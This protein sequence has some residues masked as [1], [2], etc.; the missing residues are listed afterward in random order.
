MS[1]K[2]FKDRKTLIS[3]GNTSITIQPYKL[4]DIPSLEYR[5]SVWDDIYHRYRPIALDYDKEE[6][7]LYLPSALKVN[8]LEKA[9]T[10]MNGSVVENVKSDPKTRAVFNMK[11]SPRDDIQIKALDFLLG[12]GQYVTNAYYPR[13]LLSLDTGG[14]KTFCALAAISYMKVR[15]AI[16][17]PDQALIDRWIDEIYKITDL[18]E[19]DIYI[20]KGLDSIKKIKKNI[21]DKKI[22][23]ISHRTLTSFGKHYGWTKVTKLFKI[24]KIG[25]KVFDEAHKEFRNISKIDLYTNTDKTIYLTATA[26]R[27]QLKENKI[28]QTVYS[29][30]PQLVIKNNSREENH[31]NT[32]ILQYNSNPSFNDRHKCKSIKGFSAIKFM[33][34]NMS[35]GKLAFLRA[36]EVFMNTVLSYEDGR[37]LIM[38]GLIDMIYMLEKHLKDQY[39]QYADEIGLYCSSVSKAEKENTIKNKRII[40]T[41]FKSLGTGVDIDNLKFICMSEPYSSSV[42]AKQGSGRLRQEGWY[43]ETVDIGFPDCQRQFESRKKTLIRKSKKFKIIKM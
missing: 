37:I 6:R 9:Y 11:V 21:K 32:M 24:L 29:S 42:M 19:N 20:L 7:K 40:I 8:K 15:S 33:K 2:L 34:Y 26:E 35:T 22:I 39:P 28:Y 36:I 4:G 43:F 38:V 5:L 12:R 25:V 18:E 27:S 13:L 17:V 31:I 23:I 41:T 14:G 30:V 10:S 16:I 3:V 1:K